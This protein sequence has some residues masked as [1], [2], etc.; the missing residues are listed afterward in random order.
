MRIYIRDIKFDGLNISDELSAD[1]IGGREDDDFRF[2]APVAVK[3]LIEKADNTIMIE[4]KT[5]GMY[6]SF[7]ALCLEPVEQKWEQSCS[8]DKEIS[9]DTE[10]VDLDEDL[11][12]EI[13]MR[14]PYRVVCSANCRGI[15]PGCGVNLN[16]ESCQCRPNKDL[17]IKEVEKPKTYQP[18]KNL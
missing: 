12:Q 2:I 14:F 5:K 11:R 18:F 4:A 7:C 15:C 6:K 8:F 16:T 3:C 17:S 10:F 13:I 9:K 1:F